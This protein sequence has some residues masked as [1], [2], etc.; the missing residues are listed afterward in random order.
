MVDPVSGAVPVRV[1]IGSRVTIHGT[2]TKPL[3]TARID[4]PAQEGSTAWNRQFPEGELGPE[5]R[6]FTYAFDPF[7]ALGR[8]G[9]P[10]CRSGTPG[11][12]P[13]RNATESVPTR[14]ATERSLQDLAASQP[15]EVT[16]QFTLR[17]TDGFKARDPIFLTL[18]PVPDEPPEVK[19]HLVGTRE[20]VVTPRG[21]LPVAGTI[22]DDHGL[23]RVWWAY[24]VEERPMP[25]VPAKPR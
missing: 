16:L 18:V 3:E 21:R 10:P 4:C 12:V 8:R 19:V 1:P 17:D 5:Q 24:T 20:P 9:R 13:T 22:T 15:H 2:A 14:N 11:S 25:A 6:E 23:A 7:P